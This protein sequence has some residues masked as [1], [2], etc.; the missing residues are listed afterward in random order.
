M[1]T[2]IERAERLINKWLY[3][4]KVLPAT[5]AQTN[6]GL[7]IATAIAEAEQAAYERGLADG[8]ET[9]DRICF[10]EPGDPGRTHEYPDL[11]EDWR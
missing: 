2:A 5:I 11:E 7:A 1:P 10:D 9:V 6:L 8:Q 4:S 3:E